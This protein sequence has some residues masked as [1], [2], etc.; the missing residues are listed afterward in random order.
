MGGIGMRRDDRNLKWQL[1]VGIGLWHPAAGC[2]LRT[3]WGNGSISQDENLSFR[4]HAL[5]IFE[6]AAVS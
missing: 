6:N 4:S 2:K 3:Y 5:D 1:E